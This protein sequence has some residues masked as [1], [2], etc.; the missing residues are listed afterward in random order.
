MNTTSVKYIKYSV[1]NWQMAFDLGHYIMI[2]RY[3]N[4]C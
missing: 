4:L 1:L 2:V 3:Q